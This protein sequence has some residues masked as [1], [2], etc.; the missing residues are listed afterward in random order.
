MDGWMDGFMD[1]WMVYIR[2]VFDDDSEGPGPTYI[3][4][5]ENPEHMGTWPRHGFFFFS[6]FF[7][8][9][10]PDRVPVPVPVP[11]QSC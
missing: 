3:Y 7:N 9:R 11:V 8:K 10:N 2:T 4:I 6:F 5:F 1:S